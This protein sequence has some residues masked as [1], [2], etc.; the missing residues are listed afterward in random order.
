VAE[1]RPGELT[2]FL[3]R[4]RDLV[5]RAPII[6]R[7]DDSAV[8]LARRLSEQAVGS[9]VIVDADGAPVGIV[10]D[11]DLRRKVVAA[12]RD[13][14]ATPARDIM[15]APLV[16]LPPD[17]FAFDVLLEM[18]R[19]GIRHVVLVADGRAIGV[20]S[21]RD[22]LTTQA[23]HPVTLV[24]EIARAASPEALGALGERTTALVRRLVEEGGSA[25][26]IGQL[27]A[28]LNDRIV[29][30]VLGLTLDRLHQAGDPAPVAYCWLAFGSEARREQT[31]RTDQDNG[32]VYA[33]PP[34]ELAPRA[35]RHYARLAT[36]VI[37]GLQAAGFPPC[38]AEV[39]ASNPAW[40]QPLSVWAGQFRRWIDHPSP[41]EL[42]DASIFFDLRAVE[43]EAALAGELREVI[44]REAPA[45][46]VFLG[47]LARDVVTR[48]VPLTL[49]GHVAT[50]GSGPHRG[51]IDVKGAGSLQLVGAARIAALEL[52]LTETNTVDRLR[53]AAERQLYTREEGQEISDAYQHLLRLRLVHQLAC[54]AEGRSPDN[55]V[56]PARLS[57]A[58]QLLLREALKTVD[59]VQGGLR[60]RYSTDR[61]G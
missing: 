35:A 32:L 24:R 19:R 37:Q 1:P 45:S 30:R 58:D 10:T 29:S 4:A 56:D 40:C 39:M 6:G 49:F 27:V 14:A 21:S 7:S 5:R 15:S 9:V 54:L 13:P 12:G 59:R 57:H 25:Y 22:L 36:E 18:T 16:T 17:A 42:L 48:R 61:L 60:A 20:V 8:A 44:R 52:G 31:L 3:H 43:G 28:E 38:P 46:R 11:Q 34:P 23:T 2:L 47:L 51:T 50:L 26:A 33:D 55:H 53:A 41:R